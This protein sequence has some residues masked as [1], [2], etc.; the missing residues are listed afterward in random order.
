M[1]SHRHAV[2]IGGSG[3]LDF[4]IQL[5]NFRFAHHFLHFLGHPLLLLR[6]YCCSSEYIQSALIFGVNHHP[7]LLLFILVLSVEIN[8]GAVEAVIPED[9]I[10]A[11]GR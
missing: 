3:S 7:L 6:R 4:L 1:N 8:E 11:L 10:I 2:R 9:Q 5:F